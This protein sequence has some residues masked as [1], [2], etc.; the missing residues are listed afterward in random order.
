MAVTI[1]LLSIALL[2]A[3]DQIIKRFVEVKLFPVES[4]DFIPGFLR[5]EYVENTGAAFGSF[6]NNTLLLVYITGI[7]ILAGIIAIV[8]KKF[9][10]KFLLTT[11]VIIISGGLGN[12][13]DRIFRGYVI[14]YICTEFIDFPVFN[15]ADILVCCGCG[16]LMGYLFFDIYKDYKQKKV[17]GDNVG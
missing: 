12:L 3:I 5:W 14:D 10:N 6:S 2:T 4:V 11:V 7:A 8:A 9:K 1:S 15:F 17:K 13:I 16:M